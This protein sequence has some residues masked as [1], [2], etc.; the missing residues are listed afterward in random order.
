MHRYCLIDRYLGIPYL[1]ILKYHEIDFVYFSRAIEYKS[2]FPD[3]VTPVLVDVCGWREE[4]YC[5]QQT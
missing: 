2:M 3:E 4:D 1:M 5:L